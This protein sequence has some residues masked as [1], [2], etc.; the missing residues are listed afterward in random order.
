MIAP[1]DIFKRQPGGCVRWLGVA[2]DL[3]EAK[4][5]L[6]ELG[7]VQ[8]RWYFIFS[9]ATGQRLFVKPNDEK[10]CSEAQQP[11]GDPSAVENASI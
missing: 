9:L 10:K 4:Q 6:K 11:A 7:G 3:E 8:F 1:L 5:R 2:T